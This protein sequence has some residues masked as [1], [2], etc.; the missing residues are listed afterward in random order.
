VQTKALAAAADYYCYQVVT[1]GKYSLEMN[2]AA[3]KLE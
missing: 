3:V 1:S 2:S